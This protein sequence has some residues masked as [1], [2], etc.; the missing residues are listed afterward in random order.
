MERNQELF[1]V[2]H[3]TDRIDIF[4]KETACEH[5]QLRQ[6]LSGIVG[7]QAERVVQQAFIL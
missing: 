6:G 4:Y 7:E 2:Q 3:V 5:G 1:G